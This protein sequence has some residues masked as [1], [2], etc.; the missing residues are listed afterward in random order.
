MTA[1]QVVRAVVAVPAVDRAPR[2]IGNL[3]RAADLPLEVEAVC[4]GDGI[5]LVLADGPH[6]GTVATLREA[7]VRFLACANTLSG[8]GLTA[9][10]LA[11]GVGVVPAAVWHLVRRQHEGWSFLPL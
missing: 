4:S 11:E 5:G 2:A 6:A 9:D 8:R 1:Q 7:G 10:D 3:L